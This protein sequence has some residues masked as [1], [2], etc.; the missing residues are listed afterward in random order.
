MDIVFERILKDMSEGVISVSF[1][2]KITFINEAAQ[3]ILNL[4]Q[5]DLINQSFAYAGQTEPLDPDIESQ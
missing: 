5:K 1:D 2:G 3:G 4:K